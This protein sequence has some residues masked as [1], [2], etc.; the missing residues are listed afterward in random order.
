[1]EILFSE[2]HQGALQQSIQ[3]A[4]KARHGILPLS[5]LAALLYTFIGRDGQC[6]KLFMHDLQ[7]RQ[8][9][10]RLIMKRAKELKEVRLSRVHETEYVA[11]IILC[12][13][14]YRADN[15]ARMRIAQL[16]WDPHGPFPAIK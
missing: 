1:V 8:R 10:A 5:S 16:A 12:W 3:V 4:R 7:E 13:N 14:Q 11:M 6:A 15:A 9:G 2:R